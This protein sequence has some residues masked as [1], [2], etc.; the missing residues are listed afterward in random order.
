MEIEII[1]VGGYDEV[2]RNMTAV[3]C[4]KEIVI[5]D[6]GLRIDQVMI[7][8]DAEIENMHSLDLIK[9]KAIPDDTVLNAADGTV[10]AIVC[11][12]GHLDHIGAIPKLAHRYNAPVIGTP[13]TTELIRQQ[14]SS[15]QKFNIPNKLFALKAGQRY[16]LSQG[17]T[18]EFVRVQHSIIDSVIPVLHTP[19]GAIVYALDFKLDR[20]PVIGEPPDFAR[21]RQ[22]GKEGVLALIVECTNIGRKG[23]CPSERVA[24]DLV[25]DTITSYEDDKNAIIVSTFSS[26]ISRIKTIAECAHEIGRKP[27]LLGRSME[28]YA[29]TAEQMKLVSFP[30]TTSVFGNRR[31]VDRTLRR[32]MKAGKGQFLPIVTGHQGEPGSI[33]TRMATGDT[34]YQITGG[35]K[36]LFS[37]NIIPSPLNFG[38]RHLV[39]ARL[40]LVGARIFDD[41]HVSGHAYR[42]DHYEMIQML[43]PQ[44]IIPAHGS[45]TMNAE[46]TQFAGEMGYTA[47]ST[48]HLMRNGQRLKIA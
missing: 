6:M 39:E 29:V 34:P 38:Q 23:R 48:V 21:L 46:Y 44:H 26:H 28:K 7:H 30:E 33:L 20:S 25:R 15:E 1:A 13:Y 3:R 47:N 2:G 31:T 17:L 41:L 24:R 9:I 5:F 10:R 42:E 16:T 8:E 12:H 32:M 37:A 18:L 22:I 4:G 27:V 35:D 11:S 40:K 14:I 43:S 36:V 45:M 19:R